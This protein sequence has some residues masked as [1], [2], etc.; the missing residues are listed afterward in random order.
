MVLI[1]WMRIQSFM[2][3]SSDYPEDG[4]LVLCTKFN[5]MLLDPY[6]LFLSTIFK[7][8]VLKTLCWKEFRGC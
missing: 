4:T 3:I 8:S 6:C 2:D 7:K 1:T 5:F